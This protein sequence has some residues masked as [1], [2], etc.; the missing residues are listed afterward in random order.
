MSMGLWIA[1]G[2]VVIVAIV[3]IGIYNGLVAGRQEVRNAWSQIE[4]Q[5]K[6]RHDLI[7]NLVNAV[8]DALQIEKSQLTAVIEARNQAISANTPEQ[9]IKAENTLSGALRGLFALVESYP[10]LRSQENVTGLMEELTTTENKI[11]FARQHYNDAVQAQNI[12]VAS[13]PGVLFAHTFGFSAETMFEVPE[14]ERAAVE[15]VPE[16]KLS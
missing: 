16:V 10:H 2:L 14:T 1:L 7:P 15:A 3:A 8:K 13:F 6:R 4:I 12:R 11:S 9:S 5:L